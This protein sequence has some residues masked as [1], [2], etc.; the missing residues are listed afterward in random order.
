[1]SKIDKAV[2]AENA[3]SQPES[4]IKQFQPTISNAVFES[5]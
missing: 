2:P 1:M 3:E 5:R 4:Q